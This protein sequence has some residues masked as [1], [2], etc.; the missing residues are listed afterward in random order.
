MSFSQNSAS[1]R[2]YE[3]D[4]VRCYCRQ[5]CY[6]ITSWKQGGRRFVK[7]PRSSDGNGGCGFW[8]WKDPIV[9]LREKSIILG[10][11]KKSNKMENENET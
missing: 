4:E 7:Y 6:P 5:L 2:S 10:L 8:Q 9:P 1:T 11:L 3:S